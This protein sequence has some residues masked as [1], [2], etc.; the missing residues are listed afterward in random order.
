MT[1][2]VPTHV[3]VKT[4]RL[5]RVLMETRWESNLDEVVVYEGA[6]GNIWVRPKAQFYDGRFQEVPKSDS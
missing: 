4:G 1:Q 3:H 6:D 5:Y 2:F